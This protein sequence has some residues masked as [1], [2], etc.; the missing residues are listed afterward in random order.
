MQK[1]PLVLILLGCI[2]VILC[3]FFV[4]LHRNK[5]DVLQVVFL[6][7][8]QGDSILITTVTGK[9]ILI[10]GGAYPDVD[11]SISRYMPFYDRSID[12]VIATHP[13]LD[14][15]GGLTTVLKRYTVSLF[16]Y[17]GLH[18][19]ISAYQQLTQTLIRSDITIVTAEA[20]QTMYLDDDTYMEVLSPHSSVSASDANEKSVVV[21]LVYGTSSVLLTGDASKF[22]EYDMVSVYKNNLESDILK[23]GH[24][25]SKTSSSSLFLDAIKPQHAIVSASCD[26]RFGHPNEDVIER[27][28]K[29]G[30]N[31]LNTCTEGD[32]VFESNGESWVLKK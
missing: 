6:D 30:I 28:V 17:S 5:D 4:G 31:I 1:N 10:D 3:V 18:S 24:H 11:V 22:N 23:L 20:G 12:V 21:R 27:L 19:G 13:D 29:R 25:G 8:G 32:I 2:S 16:M 14:H 7:V 15:I 9:Q 26:N